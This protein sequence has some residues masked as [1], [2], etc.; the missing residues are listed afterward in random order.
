MGRRP[1]S[2]GFF[3]SREDWGKNPRDRDATAF[4]EK[5]LSR[6]SFLPHWPGIENENFK[7]GE[8]ERVR[9]TRFDANDRSSGIVPPGNFQFIGL[10]RSFG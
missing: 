3:D 6:T 1:I 4:M 5:P 8:D 7:G 10:R 9:D 2:D